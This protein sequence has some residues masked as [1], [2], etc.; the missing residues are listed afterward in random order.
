M[1]A[2]TQAQIPLFLGFITLLFCEISIN[3]KIA[4]LKIKISKKKNGLIPKSNHFGF[5]IVF[6]N[7]NYD[8]YNET[9]NSIT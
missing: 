4:S 7:R 2:I 9:Y 3:Q 1:E 6:Q 5:K 8:L